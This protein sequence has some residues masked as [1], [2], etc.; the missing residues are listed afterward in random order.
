MSTSESMSILP[1][2]SAVTAVLAGAVVVVLAYA[3]G[4]GLRTPLVAAPVSPAPA[5]PTVAAVPGTVLPVTV[6]PPVVVT[7][8][9]PTPSSPAAAPRP[10]PPE[11][12]VATPTPVAPTPTTCAPGVTGAL[13]TPVTSLVDGLLGV[14]LLSSPASLVDCTVGSL[15]GSPCCD[16]STPAKRTVR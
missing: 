1:R 13:L 12:V 2:E 3:S 4:F 6:A 8:P 11:P 10:R 15:L 7:L 9:A 16:A 14:D 5:S